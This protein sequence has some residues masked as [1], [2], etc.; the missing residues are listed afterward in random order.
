M[1]TLIALAAAGLVAVAIAVWSNAASHSTTESSVTQTALPPAKSKT[2]G[3][4]ILEM[5]NRAHL[6]NLPVEEVEDQSVVFAK[7]RQ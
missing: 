3:I 4:S 5:H 6:E 2:P 1:R 7:K